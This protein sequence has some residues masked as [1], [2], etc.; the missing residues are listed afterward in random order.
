MKTRLL[1]VLLVGSVLAL[2]ACLVHEPNPAQADEI[3]EK[4]RETVSKGL[5]YLAKNQ[6]K[7]GHWEGDDGQ[8]PVAMTGLVGLALLME[9]EVKNLRS[10]K[11]SAVRKYAANIRKAVDWLIEKSQPGRDGLFF[12]EHDSEKKWLKYCRTEIPVGQAIQFGR[13]D[14]THYYFAQAI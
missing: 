1:F 2:T 7:D 4:Y 3:P 5:E 12:S 6:H 9:Q 8:H 11:T 10:G 13:D 14:L